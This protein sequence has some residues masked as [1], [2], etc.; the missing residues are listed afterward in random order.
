MRSPEEAKENAKIAWGEVEK[1]IASENNA[2]GID[3][4]SVNDTSLLLPEDSFATRAKKNYIYRN[5]DKLLWFTRE[6]QQL[7]E[8][9]EMVKGSKSDFDI[10]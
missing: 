7:V 6:L 9:K 8:G 10:A 3:V 5:A 1:M 2:I 4:L